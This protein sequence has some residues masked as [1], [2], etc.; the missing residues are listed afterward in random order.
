[1]RAAAVTEGSLAPCNQRTLPVQP[2]S[3]SSSRMESFLSFIAARASFAPN[4]QCLRF[5][6]V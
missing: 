1:M 4:V 6:M 2:N 5:V 3:F